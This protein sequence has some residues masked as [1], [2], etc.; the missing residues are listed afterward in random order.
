MQQKEINSFDMKK[1]LLLAFCASLILSAALDAQEVYSPSGTYRFAIKDGQELMLDEYAPAPG[2][3]TSLDGKAKPTILFMFGGGFITGERSHPTYQEWFRMLNAEGYPVITIDYRLAMKG[4]KTKG[5]ISSLKQ[6]RNA[7]QVAAEDL[8]S[9][10]KYI[11]GNKDVLH[12]DPYNMVLSGSSAGAIT[13]LE[14]DWL[15]CNGRATE[16]LPG[17]FHFAGVMPFAGAIIST[18]GVPS[19]KKAP[20]PTAFFHGTDD[21]IVDY[22]QMQVFGKGIFGS[23]K[24]AKIFRKNG[25]T[26]N[27]FR[28]DGHSHEIASMFTQ[29]F[30]EQI[31]FL[32]TNVIRGLDRRLDATIDDPV[33]PAPESWMSNRKQLYS[34][35]R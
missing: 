24:L 8:F 5:G 10:V 33:I 26:Y 17:D 23:S 20:A 34:N 28:Y 29:T 27:I 12:V 25:Y 16:E 31:R 19:Y 13:V 2:S 22:N 4:V 30:P 32:E 18:E 11:I 3:R 6:F 35:N 15:L 14:A 1:N 21:K 9:A 7:V